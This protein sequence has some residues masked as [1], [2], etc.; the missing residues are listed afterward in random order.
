MV[1]KTEVSDVSVTQDQEVQ[2]TLHAGMHT[3]ALVHMCQ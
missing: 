2:L 3:H 1:D